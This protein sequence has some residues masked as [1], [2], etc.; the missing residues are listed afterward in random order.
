[1]PFVLYAMNWYIRLPISERDGQSNVSV[2]KMQAFKWFLRPGISFEC[3]N[4]W[5]MSQ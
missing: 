4:L 5:R 1:M 2:L 3:L